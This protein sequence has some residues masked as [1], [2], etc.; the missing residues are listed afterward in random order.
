GR[1]LQKGEIMLDELIVR[2][3]VDLQYAEWP[4]FALKDDVH[5]PVDPV[6]AQD[7]GRTEPLLILEMVGDHGLAGP[8]CVA[9]R[10]SEIGADRRH[11]DYTGIPADAGAHQEP[12]L[13]G[14]V[15]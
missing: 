12:A 9:R 3:A 10:R 1:T 8:E 14:H 4:P 13:G 5:R 7:L 11:S 2:P 6:L 15:L